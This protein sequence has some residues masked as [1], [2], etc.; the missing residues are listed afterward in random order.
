MA[1]NDFVSNLAS[2]PIGFKLGLL[3]GIIALLG[4]LYWQFFYSS[5]SDELKTAKNRTNT[6]QKKS[7]RLKKDLQEWE[8]LVLEKQSLDEELKRNS[9]SSPASSELPSFFLHLQKQAAGAGV[10]LDNWRRLKEVPI[11]TYIKVPVSVEVTG[12]FYQI[13]NYFKLLYETDRIITVENM[14]LDYVATNNDTVNLNAK[15]TASTFRL[16]DGPDDGTAPNTSPV[17]P[18]GGKGAVKA[19]NQKR[20]KQLDKAAGTT[21]T[22]TKSVKPADG[23]TVGD[24]AAGVKRIKS[25]G[26]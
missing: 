16:P 25:G 14:T 26:Q 9:V 24:P 19:A 18:K 6:L 8:K 12:S 5:L 1:S 21:G 20:G 17:D 23:K 7:E 2:K 3:G 11:E 15:F 22:K 4:I 13:N 10:K